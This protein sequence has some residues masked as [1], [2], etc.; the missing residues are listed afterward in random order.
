MVEGSMDVLIDKNESCRLV[1]GLSA[2]DEEIFEVGVGGPGTSTPA[3][4]PL[5][6]ED[7]CTT[8]AV[9]DQNATVIGSAVEVFQ[10]GDFNAPH[11]ASGG[12]TE[13]AC[14]VV[15][16]VGITDVGGVGVVDVR[17]SDIL[18]LHPSRN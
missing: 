11:P 9:V 5:W 13:D 15:K 12:P 8:R 18:R 14:I 16:L 3:S 17:K 6:V 1:A 4:S 7:T 10:G 2:I